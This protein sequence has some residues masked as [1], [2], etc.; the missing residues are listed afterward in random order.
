[1]DFSL[2][3]LGPPLGEY[4]VRRLQSEEGVRALIE[5][6]GIEVGLDVSVID[7]AA[8]IEGVE[9]LGR[10]AASKLSEPGRELVRTWIGSVITPVLRTLEA[11]EQLLEGGRPNW[12][13]QWDK[14]EGVGGVCDYHDRA[15]LDRLKQFERHYPDVAGMID[16]H[17][18]EVTSLQ[19][20]YSCLYQSI[21]DSHELRAIYER[22]VSPG[23][24]AELG[25]DMKST[26]NFPE[27]VDG[28]L[29][30]LAEHTINRVER[31]PPDYTALKLWDRYGSEFVGVLSLP[32]FRELAAE[33]EAMAGRL[34]QVVKQLI[35]RLRE[36]REDLSLKHNVPY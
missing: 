20:Q 29:K 30:A 12:D 33:A 5:D 1:M 8:F 11:E 26:F 9:V 15:W 6:V 4:H 32:P 16:E 18:R 22:A 34:L 24:L 7:V 13:R 19:E 25:T 2:R 23:S 14:I 28:H 27:N 35:S 31:L 36:I 10:E 17:D 21:R 3:E